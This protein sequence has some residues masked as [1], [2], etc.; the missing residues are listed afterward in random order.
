[1]DL[2]DILSRLEGVKGYGG[3]YT[4]RCPAHADAHQ[5]LS[6]AQGEDRRILLKCHAGCHA[7]DIVRAM[8]LQMKDLYPEA[9][10]AGKPQIV[11]TYTYPTGAQKLRRSDKSFS[12][13]RPDGKGGWVYNR[14]G[15]PHS[16][17]VAGELAPP[18]VMV[19]EGEKDTDNLHARGYNV[20]S[21][22]DGAGPGK[23]RR[24]YS[25]Q[26]R[27][28]PVCVLGDNDDV[29]R[30]YA[31][32]TAAALHGVAKSVRLLDLS[33]VWPEIPEHGDI[34]DLIVVKGPDDACELLAKLERGTPEWKPPLP[35]NEVE[36]ICHG[37]GK[38]GSID[39]GQPPKEVR[40]LVMISAPDLQKAQLPPVKFLVEGI[41][42][43]GT[44]ILSA[45]SKI[46]KSW[47]E[48]DMGLSIAAG[49]RFLGHSTN[50]CGVLYLALEDSYHRLQNRMNKVLG[51]RPAPAQFYF[52]TAAPKLDDGLLDTLDDHLK[53]F[54]DTKLIIIDTLQKIRGQALPREGAYAQDYREM[55]T[56]KAFMDAR[57]VSVKFV[58][59][60]R[61]MRDDDDPFNMISG[62][63]G[64]MGAA[65]TIWTITKA[66]RL[67][68]EATLH[69]TGRDVEQSDT[70]IRFDKESWTWKPMGSADWLAEQRARLAYNESPIVK[71]IKKLLEQSPDHRWDGTAKD[72]M[73]AGRFIA[74]TYLAPN[75]KKLGRDINDLEKPLFDYDGIVH[76][77]TGNG[78]TGKKHSFYYRDLGQFEGLEEYRNEDP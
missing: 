22:E 33:T 38:H 51:G 73:I 56:V 65:D 48:L 6:V 14:Q 77:T 71:T 78:N 7:E 72:L 29:G 23:W 45:A 50:Q 2:K 58:H 54:T 21:G 16:L 28:L 10:P 4:A 55:E 60:N 37:A 74:K 12:W 44:S 70:V 36:N 69:I 41:L 76:A 66:K 62:T 68:D 53:R 27:G 1:L 52:S 43:A 26:L 46:G 39:G 30:A 47:L 57:G 34:S 67:D 24:E 49:A 63:N 64:I 9:A 61:K 25:E 5:S 40:P 8:G 31:R 15:F 13:R 11:A 59:H 32:E 19:V 18:V 3:Q 42:P 17:Y 20:V 35:N 75:E